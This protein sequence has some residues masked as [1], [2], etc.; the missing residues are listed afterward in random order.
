MQRLIFFIVPLCVLCSQLLG[1]S[2]DDLEQATVTELKKRLREPVPDRTDAASKKIIAHY[3]KAKGVENQLSSLNAVY[4]EG[5]MREGMNESTVMAWEAPKNKLR[6][7]EVRKKLGRQE[8]IIY[9]FDG[10]KAWVYDLTPKKPIVVEKSENEVRKPFR[11]STI[12]GP[13]IDSE[14]EGWVFEYKG[15]VVSRGR[16]NHL[17]KMYNQDG[18]TEYFYFDAKTFMLSRHGWD[19]ILQGSIVSKDEYFLKYRRFAGIW[20]PE[21]VEFA[22]EDQV[23][24]KFTL[25]K[26]E[27]NPEL[28]ADIFTMPQV[29]ERWL[30][31]DQ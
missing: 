6:V 12:Y 29:E 13:F 27:F 31:Q 16:H 28:D 2:G 21:V 19:E 23:Y 4:L 9:G 30:R 14:A 7:E 18:F 22:I 3:L 20:V 1:Q 17:I 15:K 5:Q 25:E 11:R 26:C 24:G 10:T 8:K